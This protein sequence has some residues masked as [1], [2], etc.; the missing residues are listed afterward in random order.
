MNQISSPQGR[1]FPTSF[2]ERLASMQ[3]RQIFE[4]APIGM[5]LLDL[6]GRWLDVNA[7][8]CRIVGYS[9]DELLHLAFRDITLEADRHGDALLLEQLL[10]GQIPS[11]QR[12]KRYVRKDGRT[13]W[14]E[15]AVSLARDDHDEPEYLI[16]QIVDINE[17]KLAYE[18]L[19]ERELTLEAVLGALPVGVRLADADGN[20]VSANLASLDIWYGAGGEMVHEGAHRAWDSATGAELG[21]ADWPLR[22]ACATG[23]G[24]E[25]QL[26]DILCFDDTPKTLLCSVLPIVDDDGRRFGAIEVMQDMTR[27]LKLEHQLM[28]RTR[29]LEGRN[30]EL[31]Q[32]AYVASHDL[33]EPLR[34][35]SSFVQLF[36]KRYAGQVDETGQSYLN[37][38]VD[39]AHRMQLLIDDLLHYSRVS[40]GQGEQTPVDLERVYKAL[41]Q[42]LSQVIEETGATLECGPLPVVKGEPG[43]MRA[44]LQNLIGNALKYH[45]PGRPPHIRVSAETDANGIATVHVQDNGIGIEQRF[46]ERIFVIFQRLHN[47]S[48]YPGSGIGLAICKRIVENHGGRLWLESTPGEGSTFH[49]TINTAGVENEAG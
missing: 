36:A 47:R 48:E 1:I 11:Y 12:E 32:F 26:L 10:D 33:Q 5:A 45:K 34:K 28:V 8:F 37:F 29:E 38:A 46:F 2:E 23:K 24:V 6:N 13:V 30:K 35:V 42:D 41:L 17:L 19:R 25:A 43:Q 31:E 44:L 16:T 4:H 18:T 22:R 39:G 3:L 14:V 40:R 7:Q 15:L 27:W 49:F 20:I 9:R 21:E